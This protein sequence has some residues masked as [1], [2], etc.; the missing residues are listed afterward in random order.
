MA[1]R[2][3]ARPANSPISTPSNG[4]EIVD[5]VVRAARG[6]VPVVAGVA[7]TTTA[8]RGRACE[9]IRRARRRRRARDPRSL[10]SDPGR[11]CRGLFQRDRGRRPLPHRALHQSA[12]SALRSFA[13]RDQAPLGG[14]EHPLHQ[15]CLDE[16]GTALVDPQRDRRADEG[17]LGLGPYPG[18]RDADR[19]RRLDGGACLHH[20]A[21]ER[22]AL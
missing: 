22:R 3:S 9:D 6:R 20:P 5:C 11:G 21:R 12:I 16:H 1:S 17:V 7:S 15:G 2:R 13:S 18:L 14:R 19:R 8:A 4:I 10:F